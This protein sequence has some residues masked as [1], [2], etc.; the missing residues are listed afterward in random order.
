MNIFNESMNN[1]CEN[2]DNSEQLKSELLLSRLFIEIFYKNHKI[3]LFF[4][5]SIIYT[6]I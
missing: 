1:L 4:E 2:F 5:D 3:T 6:K